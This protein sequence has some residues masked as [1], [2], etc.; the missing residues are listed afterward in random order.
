MTMLRQVL[1]MSITALYDAFVAQ[2]H[3]L[4]YDVMQN[5]KQGN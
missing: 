2:E 1:A 4:P 5:F 3:T